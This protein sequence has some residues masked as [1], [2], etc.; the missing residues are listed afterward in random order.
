[1]KTSIMICMGSIFIICGCKNI[2]PD[3][4]KAYD[5]YYLRGR[6]TP[7]QFL[8]DQLLDRPVCL[9]LAVLAPPS[10][11]FSHQEAER[12]I[13]QYFK[14]A[15][16]GFLWKITPPTFQ[17]PENSSS[18]ALELNDEYRLGSQE[19][20]STGTQWKIRWSSEGLHFSVVCK[21]TSIDACF[22][23]PWNGDCVEVFLRIPAE[24]PIYRE[25]VINPEGQTYRAVHIRAEYGKRLAFP[26]KKKRE[27]VSV[28]YIPQGYHVELFIPWKDLNEMDLDDSPGPGFRFQAGLLRIDAKT[29][30]RQ[31]QAYAPFPLLYD[32]HNIFGY[33]TFILIAEKNPAP[34]E[35]RAK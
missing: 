7:A 22:P 12:I 14:D 27:R 17:I 25:Y 32:G 29:K 1:M 8:T 3:V 11:V 13:E 23:E 28:R 34:A 33:A 18:D 15:Q 20:R 5:K 6:G 26:L 21:D 4:S 16:T 9:A 19:K 10:P 35:G 31:R 24:I 2:N 30:P